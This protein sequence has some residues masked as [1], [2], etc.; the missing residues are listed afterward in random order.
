MNDED[1]LQVLQLYEEIFED[2][3]NETA[4]LQMLVSPTRQAVNLARAYDAKRNRLVDDR[5]LPGHLLVIEELRRQ[6]ESIMPAAPVVNDNQ[7][8]LF[9]EPDLADTV[10][11]DLKLGA[12]P[13]IEEPEEEEDE[14]PEGIVRYPDEDKASEAPPPPLAPAV[15]PLG[16]EEPGKELDEFSDAVEA[17]LSDFTIKDES[18]Q[19]TTPFQG[20]A[21]DDRGQGL[22]ARMS[23]TGPGMDMQDED[24]PLPPALDTPVQRVRDDV[25]PILKER[26]VRIKREANVPLL[27]LFIVIAV[28]IT[29]LCMALILIPALLCLS[30]GTTGLC[31]GVSGLAGAFTAFS[32]FADILLVF[33]LSLGVT[34]IGL[35]LFWC[36]VS[37]LA[38]AVPG[39]IRSVCGLARRLCYREVEV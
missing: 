25:K 10:F 4:V 24:R 20:T 34:A 19:E 39:L 1:R 38:G 13:E 7:I 12:L 5:D 35:L 23:V 26:T 33:G 32:V 22:T 27:I 31:A 14:L 21:A 28:P 37:L 9:D 8:S 17:F 16:G 15:E 6:V 3:G 36:F 11:D 18:G 29:L 2:A 30:F